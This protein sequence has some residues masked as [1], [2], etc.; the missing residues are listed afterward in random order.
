MESDKSTR[1]QN[2]CQK[3]KKWETPRRQG[4]TPSPD[5]IRV[6]MS[7]QV[8]QWGCFSFMWQISL[9]QTDLNLS[10]KR[11]FIKLGG[12]RKGRLPGAVTTV[13]QKSHQG[14]RFF[15][16]LW[17]IMGHFQSNSSS[18][19][20]SWW[21]QQLPTWWHQRD[22]GHLFYLSPLGGEGRKREFPMFIS[23]WASVGAKGRF[24]FCPLK[25]N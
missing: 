21:L 2:K 6:G 12:Q 19:S 8:T 7:E 16:C 25:K 3:R 17:S 11:N 13:A 18:V 1:L 9:T 15:S 10:E 14:I 23:A 22:K 20:V 5:T 4:G 24:T